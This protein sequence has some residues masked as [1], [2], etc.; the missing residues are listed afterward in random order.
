MRRPVSARKNRSSRRPSAGRGPLH[1]NGG[2]VTAELPG[3][4]VHPA[5]SGKVARDRRWRMGRSLPRLTG[6]ARLRLRWHS[7]GSL[8]PVEAALAG[9]HPGKMEHER[10]VPRPLGV[11]RPVDGMFVARGSK[12]CSFLRRSTRTARTCDGRRAWRTP[13][14]AGCPCDERLRMGGGAIFAWF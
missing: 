2:Y 10:A 11:S 12:R 6:A 4:Q 9:S 3:L 14:K 8:I 5:D 1:S 7:R 13:R